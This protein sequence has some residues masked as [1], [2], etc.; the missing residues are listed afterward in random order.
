[1]PRIFAI[2]LFLLFVFSAESQVSAQEH[3][4]FDSLMLREYCKLAEADP[5]TLS[6]DKLNHAV[7]CTFYV[8]GVLDG[9]IIGTEPAKR[10][11]CRPEHS[12]F[13]QSALIVSKYLQ[14]HPEM[15][16]YDPDYL[17]IDA[18]SEAFPCKR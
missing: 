1:M 7:M 17:I 15:L 10:L 6:A 12:T 8:E 9:Y 2:V 11:V 13:L 16:H 5:T 18:L 14:D 4:K 3:I